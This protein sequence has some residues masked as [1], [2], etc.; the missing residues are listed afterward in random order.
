[1][2][3]TYYQNNIYDET[4]SYNRNDVKDYINMYSDILNL[5]IGKIINIYLKYNNQNSNNCFTGILENSSLEYI[6][7]SDPKNGKWAMFLI[8]NINYIEFDE[9]INY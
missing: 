5:N 3:N 6:I 1:M 9:K 4:S 8:D 2:N 7:A